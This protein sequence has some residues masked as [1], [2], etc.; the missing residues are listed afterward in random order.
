MN[1]IDGIP[2]FE[3]PPNHPNCICSLI[4]QHFEEPEDDGGEQIE[5]RKYLIIVYRR[6]HG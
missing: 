2:I 5:P 6:Q 3:Q 4:E 1:C